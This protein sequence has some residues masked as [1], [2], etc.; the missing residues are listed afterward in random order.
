VDGGEPTIGG[1]KPLGH[2]ISVAYKI[3]PTLRLGKLLQA[4]I[5]SAWNFGGVGRGTDPIGSDWDQNKKELQPNRLDCSDSQNIKVCNLL[6]LDD[7]YNYYNCGSWAAGQAGGEYQYYVLMNEENAKHWGRRL[8]YDFLEQASCYQNN[9]IISNAELVL[10]CKQDQNGTCILTEDNQIKLN[11]TLLTYT[12]ITR[13]TQGRWVSKLSAGSLVQHDSLDDLTSL[14]G[15]GKVAACFVKSKNFSPSN[16]ANT[17]SYVPRT[18]NK[19]EREMIDQLISQTPLIIRENFLSLRRIW[20]KDYVFTLPGLPGADYKRLWQIE[21]VSRKNLIE[22]LQSNPGAISLLVK[23][24]MSLGGT[25][26]YVIF[27]LLY[28]TNCEDPTHRTVHGH[29]CAQEWIS[30]QRKLR[31]NNV[32]KGT[33]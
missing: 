7:S 21:E 24:M 14:T 12:H 11:R 1:V 33:E 6:V 28:D 5:D 8:G 9:T 3:T 17:N 32:Q 25:Y 16:D 4:T 20:I 18:F 27:G 13:K 22:F 15:Y 10:Y 23:Q 26:E 29:N 19:H 2:P 31:K 30:Q